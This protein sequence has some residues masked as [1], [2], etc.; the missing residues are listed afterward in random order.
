MDFPFLKLN[1]ARK[2]ENAIIYSVLVFI[3]KIIFPN[4]ENFISLFF[5]E[6][7]IFG[8]LFIW[9]VY[10]MDMIKGKSES[11]LSIVINIGILGAKTLF[12]FSVSSLFFGSVVYASVSG[13]LLL[14]VVGAVIG[15]VFIGSGVYIFSSFRELFFLRQKKDSKIYFN[16][17]I[18]FFAGMF[19]S[20]FIVKLDPEMLFL[21]N[22]FF[23]VSIVLISI[24]SIR[25][26]WIAFLSN[27]QKIYLIGASILLSSIFGINF[28]LTL[29]NGNVL[30]QILYE[31]SPGVHALLNLLM[32]YGTI[33][34]GVIFFTTLFHLPTAEAFDRKAEEVS[35]LAD[36]SKLITQVFDFNE[37]ADT[38]TQTTKKVCNSDVAW[39]AIRGDDGFE[40]TAVDNIGYAE[41]NKVM[42]SILHEYSFNLN[43]VRVF[44]KKSVKVVLGDSVRYLRFESIAVAP[45]LVH[46]NVNGYLFAGNLKYYTFDEDD[47]KTIGAFADYAAV[48]LENSLLIKESIEKE[49]LEKEL[50]VAR[51][52]QRKIIPSDIPKSENLEIAALFVP[53][54][55][56]G[57]DYYDFFKLDS[58]RLAFVIADVSGKGI[59]AAFVMAEVK[60][61]FESLSAVITEPKD[62]LARVNDILISS[63]AAKEFVTAVY[64]IINIETGKLTFARA[65]HTPVLLIQ[66]GKESQAIP[67]G[68]GL[69]LDKTER[70]LPLMEQMEIQL[71]NNDI[72]CL[73]TDGITEAQNKNLENY[74]MDKFSK[75]VTESSNNSLEDIANAVMRDVSLFSKD[76]SQHDDVTLVLF[77]WFNNKKNGVS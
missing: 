35:S 61:V 74:G 72:V 77:K 65:G 21:K 11:P 25:I 10:L 53:A 43:R 30:N 49:R 47:E 15:A 68:I 16:T 71:N 64:G 57:G 66:N 23:V 24:N 36:F 44:N 70:F 33:N 34:F 17:M 12:L 76:Q 13:N 7:L 48:A 45:L 6:L 26:A 63:L 31:F 46:N 60:G 54:F 67:K 2:L 50:D 55:E 3:L 38:V 8:G 37:L 32:L 69:G 58:K 39:M 1:S 42:N 29:N 14:N 40:I 22:S 9:Y 75:L 28:A 56:V 5:N 18:V 51:E 62:L 41:S 59:S 73:F 4:A 20:N 52:I 27:K 19:F